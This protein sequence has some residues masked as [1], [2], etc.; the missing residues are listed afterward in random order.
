MINQFPFKI[1]YSKQCIINIKAQ[2][3]YREKK[4]NQTKHQEVFRKRKT[5]NTGRKKLSPNTQWKSSLD[6]IVA[7]HKNTMNPPC[8]QANICT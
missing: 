8:P 2:W 6:K 4:I 3:K 1:N 5:H 7:I